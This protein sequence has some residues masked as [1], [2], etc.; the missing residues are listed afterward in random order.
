MIASLIKT[1]KD[2]R[3]LY[4]LLEYVKGFDLFTVLRMIGLANEGVGKFY[5]ASLI[6]V[7]EYLH[8]RGIL[9]RDLKP[10]NVVVNNEG[11]IKLIDFGTAKIVHER[12]NTVIGTPHYMAPEVIMG[13][14]YGF[15]ID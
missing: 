2:D 10:E 8:D 1:Y 6:L 7:L 13:E 15:M 11:Y 3:R 5:G 12:T 9:Y 14:D 4:F